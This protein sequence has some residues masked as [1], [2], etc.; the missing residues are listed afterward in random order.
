MTK[1][2]SVMHFFLPLILFMFDAKILA[3]HGVV[4]LLHL[5]GIEHMLANSSCPSKNN[6]NRVTC[7]YDE[8]PIMRTIAKTETDRT[9]RNRGAS[10]SVFNW[11]I[12]LNV[13]N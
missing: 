1:S 10:S 13:E 9:K 12:G 3:N 5:Y 4:I 6:H 11:S 7:H 2:L 8:R